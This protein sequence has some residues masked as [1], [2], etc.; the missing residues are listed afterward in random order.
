MF[1][2]YFISFL[3]G[4]IIMWTITSSLLYILAIKDYK[5]SHSKYCFSE[6]Y[7]DSSYYDWVAIGGFF[8]PLFIWIVIYR[9]IS[10]YIVSKIEKHYGVD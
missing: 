7:S 6:W 5:L 1:W 8:W 9:L 2:I 3:I 4:Y 10:I